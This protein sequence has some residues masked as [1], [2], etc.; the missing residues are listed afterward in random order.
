MKRKDLYT[1]S[2]PYDD[3]DDD[4]DINN[5]DDNE[6]KNDDNDDENGFGNILVPALLLLM[7]MIMLMMKMIIK[8]I[9][10]LE[11]YEYLLIFSSP[12]LRLPPESNSTYPE[13]EEI[14]GKILAM[15]DD[16]YL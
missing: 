3:D 7:I 8:M 12:P 4:E 10:L 16:I 11:R 5:D 9:F 15:D 2:S 14:I 1:C 13:N 6:N